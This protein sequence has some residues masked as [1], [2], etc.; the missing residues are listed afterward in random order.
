MAEEKA[1]DTGKMILKIILGIALVALGVLSLIIW[2]KDLLVL[3]KG[4]VGAVL[5]LAGIVCFA[6]AKE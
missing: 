1:T 3:I 4:A 2:W 6:I 5:I